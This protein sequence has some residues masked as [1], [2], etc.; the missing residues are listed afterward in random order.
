MTF[1][2][3]IKS[4]Y[5]NTGFSDRDASGHAF[6]DPY[7]CSTDIPDRVRSCPRSAVSEAVDL[8]RFIIHQ[9]MHP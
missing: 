4:L 2:R 3:Q 9:R 7:I 1:E 8:F 5:E 6:S